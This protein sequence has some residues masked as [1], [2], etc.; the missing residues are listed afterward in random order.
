MKSVNLDITHRCT[1]ECP[2]CDRIPY[3][4]Y[5]QRVP[6]KDMTILEYNK[7]IDYFDHIIFCGNKADPVFN[8]YF[9][10]FLNI[11]YR[12]NISCEVHNAATG[13]SLEWYKKAFEANPKAVWFFGIDGLPEKSHMY[14][15]NQ[16][17]VVL[18]NAMKLCKSLGLETVWNHI[19]FKYNEDDMSL[20][21]KIADNLD[22]K[23]RFIKSSRFSSGDDNLK[24]TGI[25][26]YITRDYD[27]VVS[28][29]LKQ[30]N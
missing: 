28:Q 11:N 6:G 1:L 18:F 9:I 21:K 19:I 7:I 24:P 29:M 26:N 15:K 16:D 27:K 8:P 25:D 2:R 10:E 3:T 20:C 23:I 5:G 17:G 13:K 14:R 4:K 22:I 12:N 30:S